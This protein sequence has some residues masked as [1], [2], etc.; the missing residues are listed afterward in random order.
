LRKK[1]PPRPDKIKIKGN[2]EQELVRLACG[3]PPE[4]T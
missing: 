4:G 3:N 2:L 1:Q